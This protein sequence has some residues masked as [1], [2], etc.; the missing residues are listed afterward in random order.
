LTA[1]ILLAVYQLLRSP[2]LLSAALAGLA[3][4]VGALARA[5]LAVLAL[6]LLIGVAVGLRSLDWPA[7]A[8]RVGLAVIVA[9]VT[10]APWVVRNL[11]TFR[12]PT[13]LSTAD[14]A[15]LLGAN[16]DATYRDGPLLGAWSNECAFGLKPDPDPSVLAKRQRDLARTYVEHHLGRLPVVMAARV[17]RLWD[18]YRP[19][20]TARTEVLDGRPIWASWSGLGVFWVLVPLA[21]VGVVLKRRGRRQWPLLVPVGLVTALAATTY[22]GTRFRAPAEVS[23]IVLAAVGLDAGWRSVSRR[24]TVRTEAPPVRPDPTLF[25]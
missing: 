10:V 5:E 13:Y 15:V 19:F 2:T 3:C 7:R 23:I 4:G 14:G 17:G 9:S 18:I 11:T 24:R 16:C 21:Y 12:E 8:G 22:G 25:A 6:L 1:L 20:E